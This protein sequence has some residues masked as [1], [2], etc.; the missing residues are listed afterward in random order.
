MAKIVFCED[1]PMIRKLITAAMR[2]SGHDVLAVAER[3]FG[4]TK[5]YNL[6]YRYDQWWPRP[7]TPRLALGAS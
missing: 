2:D 4:G 5:A 1:D 7:L 6:S 3:P